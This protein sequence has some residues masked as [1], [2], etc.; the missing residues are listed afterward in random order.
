MFFKEPVPLSVLTALIRGNPRLIVPELWTY[1]MLYVLRSAVRR[2][3]ITPAGARKAITFL[4]GI[5]LERVALT[6]GLDS[7]VLEHALGYNLSAYDAGYVVLAQSRG[8]TLYTADKAILQLRSRLD[9]IRP[10]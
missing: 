1:E 10:L 9:F 6:A 5:P 7:L 8:A 2:E 4:D 3:R